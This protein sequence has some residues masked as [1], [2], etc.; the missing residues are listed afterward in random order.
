MSFKFIKKKSVGI[1]SVLATNIISLSGL[2]FVNVIVPILLVPYLI[3]TL[4]IAGFGIVALCQAV[5]S[6]GVMFIDYGFNFTATR[7]IAQS[8]GSCAQLSSIFSRVMVCKALLLFLFLFLA[9][10]FFISSDLLLDYVQVYLLFMIQVVGQMLM[11]TFLFHGMQNIRPVAIITG[12]IKIISM[13][14]IFVLVKDEQD[15]ILVAQ[16]FG[17][18]FLISGSVALI[19]ALK[20]YQLVFSW[21]SCISVKRELSDG[22]NVFLASLATT[23]YTT[24]VP[25]ILSFHVSASDVGIFSAVQRIV[26]GLK[27]LLGPV[28]QAIFP[29]IGGAIRHDLPRALALISLVRNYFLILYAV[30]LSFVMFFIDDFSNFLIGGIDQSLIQLL[31]IMLIVPVFVLISNLYGV[32]YMLNRGLESYFRNIIT[33]S[34]LLALTV[35]Y[36]VIEMYGII[37]AG[38]VITG[39][40]MIIALLV[41]SFF[42]MRR[43]SK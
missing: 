32:Q 24:L 42:M 43:E 38:F 30:L 37:G 8:D 2:Q 12:A 20:K 41:L 18:G 4:G 10:A 16:L 26:N 33:W 35:G 36:F 28:A 22:F 3:K 25:L 31:K 13:L 21:P 34:S 7:K 14:F 27:G 17:V 40:E 19:Y 15:I 23:T 6:Y 11:P 1:R 5:A 29:E 39:T 9:F